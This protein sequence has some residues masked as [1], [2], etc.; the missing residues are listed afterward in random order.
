[1]SNSFTENNHNISHDLNCKDCGALLHF[2]PGTQ[3]LACKYCG[4]QNEIIQNNKSSLKIEE[5]DFNKF[6]ANQIVTEEKQ[7]IATVNCKNCGATT[8]L[9]RNI[10]SDNCVFC[11]SPLVIV[12]G[13]TSTI[14]KPK[15]ILPFKVERNVA[16]QS[17]DEW[18]K[19]LWFAPND[20]VKRSAI[21]EKI[22]GVYMPYWTYD[23]KS[24]CTYEGE[25]GDDYETR[26]SKGNRETKTRWTDV[27]GSV[28][29][30][31]DDVCVLASH[32]LPQENTRR[33]EPWDNKNLVAFNE[34]YLSGFQTECY[35]LDVKEGLP[36]AKQIME[37]EIRETICE[38]IGGDKQRISEMNP[39]YRD[40]TFKHTLFP[41]WI[42]AYKYNEKSYRFIA[43]GRTGKIEGQRPI[44]Y[45]KV[46]LF[47]SALV[48]TGICLASLIGGN[49]IFVI[50]IFE[51]IILT[52]FITW[53]KKDF[54][55]SSKMTEALEE[56]K[57]AKEKNY[58][59]D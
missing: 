57:A 51:L 24:Y 50:G 19:S 29:N 45:I 6:I 49:S 15:Y 16:N 18:L 33:L 37:E 32:S 30:I 44:S 8:T 47:L 35:Q 23:A 46:A 7:T 28:S 36:L 43:N 17:F 39:V 26:D 3:K 27:S 41:I 34:A 1:M 11:A 5:I 53:W 55:F 12:N 56:I 58:K 14:I 25:R 38:D 10:T 40:I 52:A 54:R 4:A 9:K 31:F 22:N 42:S 48:G 13:S 21:S 2:A 59:K 20:L